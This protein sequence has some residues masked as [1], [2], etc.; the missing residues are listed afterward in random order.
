MKRA[1]GKLLVI[2]QA[3]LATP[4]FA[5][6]V[7]IF[8][9]P[10]APANCSSAIKSMLNRKLRF[11]DPRIPAEIYV[12]P[13]ERTILAGSSGWILSPTD[14]FS[15]FSSSLPANETLAASLALLRTANSLPGFI[16]C[17]LGR[18]CRFIEPPGAEKTGAKFTAHHATI[19]GSL[20]VQAFRPGSL[21]ANDWANLVWTAPEYVAIIV[22]PPENEYQHLL[23]DWYADWVHEMTH[24]L[25]LQRIGEWV[26]AIKKLTANGQAVRDEAI[27]YLRLRG[28]RQ[29]L[30]AAF[31]YLLTE[32][33]AHQ[34]DHLVQTAFQP[35]PEYVPDAL[36]LQQHLL[37][38]IENLRAGSHR[39]LKLPAASSVFPRS[40]AVFESMQQTIQRAAQYP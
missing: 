21:T 13:I 11:L 10:P 20:E 5:V 3:A 40:R 31:F 33:V 38:E 19:G 27:Q 16:S 18:N 28:S 7:Q 8:V 34:T 30:D 9:E 25:V 2:L 23:V 17:I 26:N 37:I 6:S 32:G 15:R 36:A 35:S 39:D 24:V 22:Q 1:L 29:I 4:L 14:F 12:K